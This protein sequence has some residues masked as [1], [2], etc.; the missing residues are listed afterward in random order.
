[1]YLSHTLHNACSIPSLV[2]LLNKKAQYASVFTFLC[3]LH[4]TCT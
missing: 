3:T 4:F 2:D 1:M